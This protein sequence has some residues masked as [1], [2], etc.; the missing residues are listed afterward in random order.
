MPGT[1]HHTVVLMGMMGSGKTTIGRV[2]A[3]RTGWRYIDNDDSVRA[4]TGREPRQIDASDGEAALHE[5]E[6]KALRHALAMP[7]PLIVGAAAGVVE[8]PTLAAQL[9]GQPAVV[10]L[11]TR[12]ET[13]RARIGTGSDRRG[14]ATD[15]AWLRARVAERDAAY[16]ELATLTIETDLLES[17]AIATRILDWLSGE[18]DER[19]GRARITR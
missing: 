18:T 15:L 16:R 19:T 3:E 5:A 10:Y 6:V 8:S 14:D 13:L 11:R 2:L 9:R 4:V 12:P 7:T 1:P 17:E